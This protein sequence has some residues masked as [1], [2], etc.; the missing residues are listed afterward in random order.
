MNFSKIFLSFNFSY[1]LN[2]PYI[3]KLTLSKYF[4]ELLAY[5]PPIIRIFE[6]FS[7]KNIYRIQFI[8][9]LERSIQALFYDIIIVIKIYVLYLLFLIFKSFLYFMPYFKFFKYCF[10]ILT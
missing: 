6:F 5:N 9:T 4:C 2:L 7:V 10:I 1:P 8:I 3:L